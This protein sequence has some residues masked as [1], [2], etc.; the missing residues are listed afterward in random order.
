MP[1]PAPGS[2]AVTSRLR[3]LR[4]GPRFSVLGSRRMLAGRMGY[5][6]RL[7]ESFLAADRA[8]WRA[9]LAEHHKRERAI[10]VIFYK[11]HV[12]KPCVSYDEAVEEA[13]CFGWIDGL[14]KRIDDEKH[15]IRFTPRR[16]TSIWSESNKARVRRLIAKR[17]MTPAGL[18]LVAAA[19]RSG[20]W[21]KSDGLPKKIVMPPELERSLAANPR[22]RAFFATLAPSYRRTYI[23]WILTAKRQETRDRR[24]GIVVTRCANG[25]KPGIDL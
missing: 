13:L 19:K 4:L 17:R 24:I 25:K 21:G 3:P 10:W 16:P 9:W 12:P 15:R 23:G 14:R 2:S 8:T 7:E 11:K 5:A 18:R 22:A 6:P 1:W 20:E